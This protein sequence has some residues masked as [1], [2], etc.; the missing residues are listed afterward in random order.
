M[1]IDALTGSATEVD[2]AAM[3]V[4]A[5]R[6]A[7][8]TPAATTPVAIDADERGA[9]RVAL[10]RSGF[11]V[12]AVIAVGLFLKFVLADGGSVIFGVLMAWFAAIAI[13]PAVDRL[14]RHMRRGLATGIVMLGLVL[15]LVV[16][17]V[18]FGQLLVDQVVQLLRGLPDLVDRVVAQI[19]KRTGSNY[20]VA[21]IIS[22]L[23]I[24]PGQVAGYATE[25]LSGVLG[26]L[27]SVVGSVFGLFTFGLFTFY[28]SADGPR[29][30][31]WIASLFPQRMQQGAVTVWDI[32]AQK[33]GSYVAARLILA[34]I[35]TACSAVVFAL[36]G[37]P[38]W[39]AL[40][41]WTGFVAQFVPTIG[42]YI[43]I[44]LPVLVGLLSPSP[45]IGL[46]ALAWGI[47]YQQVENL[48]I[49]PRISSRA[50]DVHPAAAFGFVLLGTALF[51]VSGALL[52]IPVGAMVLSLGEM[53]Q[54]RHELIPSLRGADGTA[55]PGATRTV[56][57]T[58]Q[59]EAQEPVAGTPRGAGG[60][61]RRA[62]EVSQPGCRQPGERAGGG[63]DVRHPRAR[64]ASTS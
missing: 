9:I 45:W 34:T 35:N 56:R 7:A 44:M 1:T 36:I 33:T 39:L 19:N 23:H 43:A 52:A 18:A 50:V 17:V 12:L 51:G 57:T 42:T 47:L 61:T 40:A 53:Y 46:A 48:T 38:S 15:A 49:E 41:I 10:I 24:D 3:S 64:G 14:A 60:R 8:T 32:T 59:D 29:F 21:G 20:D 6:A 30:R 37:L 25:V 62:V 58:A 16:F 28:L 2:P 31:L 27:G 63:G 11:A 4:T 54:K 22:S 5:D 26:I 13:A 55:D